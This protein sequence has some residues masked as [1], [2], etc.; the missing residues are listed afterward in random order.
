MQLIV[1]LALAFGAQAEVKSALKFLRHHHASVHNKHHHAHAKLKPEED[2]GDD[3]TAV[4]VVASG[5]GLPASVAGVG[6]K[7]PSST[8]DLVN[9]K[10]SNGDADINKKMLNEQKE[11]HKDD[12]DDDEELTPEEEKVDHLHDEAEDIVTKLHKLDRN[13][14]FKKIQADQEKVEQEATPELARVLAAT[15]KEVY[16]F[17]A[18]MLQEHL[19]HE[20]EHVQIE[21][22]VAKEAVKKQWDDEERGK[23]HGDDIKELKVEKLESVDGAKL[24]K[25]ADDAP[26]KDG[27][28]AAAKTVG[29]PSLTFIL[30]S[31]LFGVGVLVV[32][33]FALK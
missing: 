18:P 24:E 20:L 11:E 6:K 9:E 29:S 19:K 4:A 2:K 12:D 27:K 25:V 23:K 26:K 14:Y 33:A 31:V 22:K 32:T 15:R 5:D 30:C 17:G 8:N 13:A 28:P 7:K 10:E 21:E 16:E 1:L 3:T